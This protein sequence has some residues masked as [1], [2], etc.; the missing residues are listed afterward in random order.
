M[1]IKCSVIVKVIA[2]SPYAALRIDLGEVSIW[3]FSS[4]F[5]N[6]GPLDFCNG[7]F[8]VYNGVFTLKMYFSRL[9]KYMFGGAN[10]SVIFNYAK[11]CHLEDM[12]ITPP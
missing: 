12:K 2:N 8:I 11:L 9:Q 5:K 4:N 10:K 1:E 7:S 6:E 3:V